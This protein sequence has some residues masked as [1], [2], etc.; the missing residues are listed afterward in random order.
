L[1]VGVPSESSFLA[2]VVNSVLNMPP[3]HVT[4]WSDRALESVSKLFNLKTLVV[5]HENVADYHKNWYLSTL[6]QAIFLRYKI[7]DLSL[8]RRIFAKATSVL[9]AFALKRIPSDIICMAR[10]HTV[11]AVYQKQD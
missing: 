8:K 4:R 6:F 5:F 10:G 2:H 3:H 7:I 9:T 1:I 11:V